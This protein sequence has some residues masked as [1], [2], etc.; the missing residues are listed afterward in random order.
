MSQSGKSLIPPPSLDEK[1]H[2]PDDQTFF[3]LPLI[4]EVPTIWELDEKS[5]ELI[6]RGR[7]GQGYGICSVL[8]IEP[9]TGVKKMRI[10]VRPAFNEDDCLPREDKDG[11]PY[12]S[13]EMVVGKVPFGR[14]G[15]GMIH[16]GLQRIIENELKIPSRELRGISF[17]GGLFK[18]GSSQDSNEYKVYLTPSGEFKSIMPTGA[19]YSEKYKDDKNAL[20]FIGEGLE[21]KVYLL[22]NG[23]VTLLP[24]RK[25]VPVM[26]LTTEELGNV[27]TS[28][29]SKNELVQK[30]LLALDLHHFIRA[31]R[32][33]S[34]RQNT[35][36]IAKDPDFINYIRY[37]FKSD[38]DAE[39]AESGNV[40]EMLRSTDLSITTM[41]AREIL[42]KTG[43]TSSSLDEELE[44][45]KTQSWNN[46]KLE[47]LFLE[48]NKKTPEEKLK[49]YIQNIYHTIGIMFKLL[50]DWNN[51]RSY[52]NN[53]INFG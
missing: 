20:I 21:R 46:V 51:V 38:F 4:G 17:G 45:I 40:F 12:E 35:E 10:F 18:G 1:T 19:L 48:F 28:T 30:A 5:Q 42:I 13:N 3:S 37:A 50:N 53:K 9:K 49:V 43:T 33:K 15:V 36:A 16:E 14:T 7:A 22:Q 31:I 2:S 8:Q 27:S 39:G 44:R 32:N 29:A 25:E 26:L 47:E 23:Y 52:R 41:Q 6:A 24:D 34:S 11:V